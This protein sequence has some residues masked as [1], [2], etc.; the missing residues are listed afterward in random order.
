MANALALKA[1]R[2]LIL[3]HQSLAQATADKLGKIQSAL[4][5][6]RNEEAALKQLL[7]NS[8]ETV[9]EG[10]CYRVSITTPKAPTKIDWKALAEHYLPSSVIEGALSSFTTVGEPGESRVSVKSLIGV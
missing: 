10:D 9:V 8:G 6:L 5:P 2:L 7:R 3:P 1:P 4:A